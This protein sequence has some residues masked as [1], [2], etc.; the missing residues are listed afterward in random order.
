MPDEKEPPTNV[1]T[2]DEDWDLE[3]PLPEMPRDQTV[4]H[5]TVGGRGVVGRLVDAEKR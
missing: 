4:L 3:P 5:T 2:F 1:L